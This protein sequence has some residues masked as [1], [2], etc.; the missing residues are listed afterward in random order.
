M[1]TLPIEDAR[2]SRSL[3]L[4]RLAAGRSANV[5]SVEELFRDVSECGRVGSFAVAS[6]LTDL[7]AD[8]A[9]TVVSLG[10]E[11]A[12][13]QDAT[14][15]EVAVAGMREFFLNNPGHVIDF[16]LV[17]YLLLHLDLEL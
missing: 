8:H 10:V 7:S 9:P 11:L 15:R 4:A 3:D 13:T 1:S 14:I 12:N 5:Q 6:L 2:A 16:E 17:G